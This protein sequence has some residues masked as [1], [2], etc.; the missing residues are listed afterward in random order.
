[1]WTYFRGW[2]RKIGAITLGLACV[3]VA[4]W[5]R[6]S[7]MF[8][9]IE[10]ISS[11]SKYSLSSVRGK[12]RW[13]Y[14]HGDQARV[15]KREF[16]FPSFVLDENNFDSKFELRLKRWSFV[17]SDFRFMTGSESQLF[18]SDLV[19]AQGPPVLVNQIIAQI[20]YWSIVLPLTV[21]SA[22]CLLTKPRTKT[23]TKPEPSNA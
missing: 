6:S 4:E 9:G 18:Y 5:V 20:P 16:R 22:W 19:Q 23:A 8:D 1:M 12:I 2:K 17:L 14:A 7:V 21:I 10:I 3:F 11:N 13:F 15:E